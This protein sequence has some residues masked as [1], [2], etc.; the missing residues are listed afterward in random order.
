MSYS[1]V[2][3]VFL[4]VRGGSKKW[5]NGYKCFPWVVAD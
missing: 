3:L 2:F 4:E 1:L 5:K